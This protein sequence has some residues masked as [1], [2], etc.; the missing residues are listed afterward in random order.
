MTPN[1]LIL[2][3]AS[4][5]SSFTCLQKRRDCPALTVSS[6]LA[7]IATKRVISRII[8]HARNQAPR[9]RGDSE[10]RGLATGGF[11]PAYTL[12]LVRV[13]KAAATTE[14]GRAHIVLSRDK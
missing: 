12:A 9:Q 1:P 10:S 11:T 6:L 4:L 3:L 7:A 2:P 5:L 14:R 8:E 13:E